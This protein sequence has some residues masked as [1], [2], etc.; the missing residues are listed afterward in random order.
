MKKANAEGVKQYQQI[1]DRRWSA[2]PWQS[3][4]GILKSRGYIFILFYNYVILNFINNF[5][6]NIIDLI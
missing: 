3:I 2:S 1:Y 5:F 6:I 4:T